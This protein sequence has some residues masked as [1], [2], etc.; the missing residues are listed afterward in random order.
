[1]LR[2]KF[3][4]IQGFFCYRLI[5]NKWSE[6]SDTCFETRMKSRVSDCQGEKH[7]AALPDLSWLNIGEIH[8]VVKYISVFQKGN[9]RKW[10]GGGRECCWESSCRLSDNSGRSSS[11]AEGGESY[12]AWRRRALYSYT[13]W[14]WSEE[15]TIQSS[16]LALPAGKERKVSHHNTTADKEPFVNKGKRRIGNLCRLERKQEFL[17]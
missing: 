15:K 10:Q 8:F 17:S 13:Y 1:M 14:D 5:T 3:P 9:I 12:P 2:L 6:D 7:S 4:I 16:S 11:W